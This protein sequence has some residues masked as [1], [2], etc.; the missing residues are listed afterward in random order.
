MLVLFDFILGT[1]CG[2]SGS[3]GA[4]NADNA[5]I[6]PLSRVDSHLSEKIASWQNN[7]SGGH[8]FFVIFSPSFFSYCPLLQVYNVAAFK[9]N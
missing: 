7:E 2:W 9:K 8:V 5:G 1:A 3:P 4:N 6:R